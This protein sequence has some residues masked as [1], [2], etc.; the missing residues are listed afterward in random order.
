MRPIQILRCCDE[1]LAEREAAD[2]NQRWLWSIRR[3]IVNYCI[4]RLED[5]TEPRELPVPL[6]E[7][8]IHS[9]RQNH[10]L[11]RPRSAPAAPFTANS[12]W[13]SQIRARVDAYLAGLKARS[14][15]TSPAESP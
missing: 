3:K 13:M 14:A 1:A 5:Q 4:H 15:S 8:E 11:L 10:P 6:S 2:V 7:Q 9:I 12:S